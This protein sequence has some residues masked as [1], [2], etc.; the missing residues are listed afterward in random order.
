MQLEPYP[1]YITEGAR[2]MANDAYYRAF[3]HRLSAE[4]VRL[5]QQLEA[6]R[7]AA[8]SFAEGPVLDSEYPV[9]HALS[10]LA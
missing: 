6:A 7:T 8:I 4:V 5:E 2:A 9:E 1:P 3:I 10:A